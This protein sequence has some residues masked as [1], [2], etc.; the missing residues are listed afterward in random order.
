MLR[1]LSVPEARQQLSWDASLGFSV[2]RTT[3]AKNRDRKCPRMNVM[4]R[5][6]TDQ[7]RQAIWNVNQVA[8]GSNAEANLVDAL[9][10]G[11][12]VEVSLVA[13][14]DKEIVGHIL[15]S[16]VTIVATVGTLGALSLAPMAV[17]P[18]HQRTGIGTKLVAAGLEICRE[19]GL[20][21][22]VVLGHPEF[23]QRFG[24]SAELARR[25]ESPFGGGEVWMTVELV[26]GALNG[27]VG[28][29]EYS[30]PFAAF[31]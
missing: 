9:R 27:V 3:G 6:E 11:G 31:G 23:Y 1:D 24:F 30:R 12:F 7:D 10:D 25:L 21:I 28:R 18:S 2:N 29:V 26:Q 20:E 16:R 17:L 22:V 4:I 8:F 15:L 5:P 13:E 19:R 14:V